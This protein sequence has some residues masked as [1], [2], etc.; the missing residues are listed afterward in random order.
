MCGEGGN[1]IGDGGRVEGMVEEGVV[2][3]GWRR[4]G[5]GRGRFL[6]KTT[7]SVRS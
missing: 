3:G 4:G 5:E 1:A 2:V 7:I 6:A